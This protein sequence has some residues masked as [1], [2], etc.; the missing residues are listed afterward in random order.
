[1]GRNDNQ[2]KVRGNRIEVGEIENVL[3]QFDGIKQCFVDVQEDKHNNKHLI[4]YI[5]SEKK[6]NTSE[7]E[8][9]LKSRLPIYMLP[10]RLIE[11]ER[12]PLTLNGKIDR[13]LIP[14]IPLSSNPSGFVKPQTELEITLATLWQDL[15]KV[16]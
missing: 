2:I 13:A 3:Y 9:F 16:D 12:I 5:V 6:L 15:L 8:V 10:Q 1:L 7:I 4:G 11:L 14:T